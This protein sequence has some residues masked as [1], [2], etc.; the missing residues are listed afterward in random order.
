MREFL[1][2]ATW[3]GKI[4]LNY[5]QHHSKVGLIKRKWARYQHTS[6][7]ASRLQMPRVKVLMRQPP[8]LP[9]YDGLYLC[10]LT[11]YAMWQGAHAL[12]AMSFQP[13]WT[14][15]PAGSRVWSEDFVIVTGKLP[16]RPENCDSSNGKLRALGCDILGEET[17]FLLSKQQKEANADCR[18]NTES[19]DFCRFFFFFEL[20][21]SR[22]FQPQVMF[23]SCKM[24]MLSWSQRN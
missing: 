10:F 20:T 12:A 1:A 22:N 21:H 18:E 23:A 3:G 14:I 2:A 6:L 4:P 7:S 13:W 9:G 11:S 5:R 19:S 17:D 8:C 16:N 24:Y 15:P